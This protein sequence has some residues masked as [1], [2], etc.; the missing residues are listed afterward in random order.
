[1]LLH[2]GMPAEAPNQR[3]DGR[4]CRKAEI[5]ER[6]NEHV[7]S[8]GDFI[9]PMALRRPEALPCFRKRVRPQKLKISERIADF[10]ARLK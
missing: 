4:L 10:A 6:Y 7:Y 3:D 5:T 9:T 8:G 1:M 2:E